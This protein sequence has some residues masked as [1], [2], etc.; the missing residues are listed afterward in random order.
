MGEMAQCQL[1]LKCN[2]TGS[3]YSHCSLE[4]YCAEVCI[5]TKVLHILGSVHNGDGVVLRTG[6]SPCPP[7]L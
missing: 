1:C 2:K 5:D 6:F 4:R 3:L 7:L